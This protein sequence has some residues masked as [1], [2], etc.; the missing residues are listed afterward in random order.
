MIKNGQQKGKGDLQGILTTAGL[1]TELLYR[2][3]RFS[4]EFS[5][6]FCIFYRVV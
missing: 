3:V 4:Q 2:P 6:P 5:C 1:G